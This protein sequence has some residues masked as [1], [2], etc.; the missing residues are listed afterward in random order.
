MIMAAVF[1][2]WMKRSSARVDFFAFGFDIRHLTGNQFFY[3]RPR[4]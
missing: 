2:S 1:P 3:C 4:R